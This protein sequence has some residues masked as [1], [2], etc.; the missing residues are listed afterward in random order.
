M[1][2]LRATSS[3][4][5]ASSLTSASDTMP[6]LYYIVRELIHRTITGPNGL[7]SKSSMLANLSAGDCCRSSLFSAMFGCSLHASTT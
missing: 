5:N 7:G 2:L 6:P 3:T 4:G 1:A